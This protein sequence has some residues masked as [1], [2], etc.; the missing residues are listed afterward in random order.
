MGTKPNELSITKGDDI[1]GS[2]IAFTNCIQGNFTSCSDILIE[3]YDHKKETL[4]YIEGEY[5]QNGIQFP[6]LRCLFFPNINYSV[7]DK[8]LMKVGTITNL[9]NGFFQQNFTRTSKFGIEL[10]INIGDEH[11]TLL[12]YASVFL[13]YCQFD[14]PICCLGIRWY[15]YFL[16]TLTFWSIDLRF[17]QVQILIKSIYSMLY[18]FGYIF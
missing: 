4:Y 8:S 1:I 18:C 9:Y 7:Y 3:I 11:K 2:M 13:D 12:L 17:D 16:F 15:I 14:T 5:C 6:C 10:P